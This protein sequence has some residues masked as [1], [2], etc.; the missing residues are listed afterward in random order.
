[1]I[2]RK[3][4]KP[5]PQQTIKPTPTSFKESSSSATESEFSKRGYDKTSRTEWQKQDRII[6]ILRSKDYGSRIRITWKEKWKNDH[7]IVYDYSKANGPV[8]IVPIAELFKTD[9]V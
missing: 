7:A 4:L 3:K 5:I 8:C 2:I 1:M 9:F 6:H